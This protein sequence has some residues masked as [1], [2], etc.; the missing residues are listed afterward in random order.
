MIIL[1]VPLLPLV[2]PLP[3]TFP[4]S[5][6]LTYAY[7]STAGWSAK[8]TIPFLPC[9]QV[10]KR[11]EERKRGRGREEER[12]RGREEERKRGREEERGRRGE[13]ERGRRQAD[14]VKREGL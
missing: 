8:K 11:E 12:K 9:L 7:R 13:G 5:R 2:T 6:T 4:S 10:C 3:P 1:Y 14:G